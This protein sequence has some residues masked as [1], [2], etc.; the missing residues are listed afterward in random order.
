LA[1]F[2]TPHSTCQINA[3]SPISTGWAYPSEKTYFFVATCKTREPFGSTTKR[4]SK[5]IVR[6]YVSI[7]L[8]MYLFGS[9]TLE[10]V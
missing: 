10:G 6:K 7:P 3:S 5:Y 4:F 8:G 2:R 1:G 9:L